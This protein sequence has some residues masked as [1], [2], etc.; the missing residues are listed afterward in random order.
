M[1]NNWIRRAVTTAF[2][3]A[4]ATAPSAQAQVACGG[5]LAAGTYVMT[6]DILDCATSPAL[7]LTGDA[8]LDMNAHS[9]T[10]DNTGVNGVVLTGAGNSIYNGKVSDCATGI[11]LLG[12]GDHRVSAMLL[13]GNGAEGVR[14]VSNKN[15]LTSLY[16]VD[17]EGPQIYIEGNANKLVRCDAEGGDT[18]GVHIKG[19]S[20]KVVDSSA[21]DSGEHG[22]RVEVGGGNSFKGCVS[23]SNNGDGFHI[24]GGS[25]KISSSVATDN[26][27]DGFSVDGTG[28]SIAK[29]TAV[30]NGY[31]FSLGYDAPCDG[32]KLSGSRAVANSGHGLFA[33]GVGPLLAKSEVKGSETGIVL[34]GGT[35]ETAGP[36]ATK[37]IVLGPS[38]FGVWVFSDSTTVS[39]NVV[40]GAE[41]Y[42][43]KDDA[44][45]C[46][47][48][49]WEGNVFATRL[50]GCEE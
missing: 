20:N 29:S 37:N 5:T 42:D 47:T 9:I 27:D 43:L 44:L 45:A 38:D 39:K 4:V 41:D 17:N 7:T 21:S 3:L 31:G 15:A 18:S 36:T 48:N 12:E 2:L 23:T 26:G 35:V 40:V 11:S 16:A 25:T 33:A 14:V 30:N 28:S 19:D 22:F 1:G 13:S 34:T 24:E 6:V 50:Q 10:C 32:C 49:T 46:G 8:V